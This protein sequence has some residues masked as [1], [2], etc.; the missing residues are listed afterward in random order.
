MPN[1]DTFIIETEEGR[2]RVRLVTGWDPDRVTFTYRLEILEFVSA[3][4]IS[5]EIRKLVEGE[6][7]N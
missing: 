5:G 7:R 1:D 6:K 2:A 4:R 3:E